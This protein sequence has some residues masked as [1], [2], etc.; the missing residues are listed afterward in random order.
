MTRVYVDPSQVDQV[1]VNLAVNARD[2][3]PQGSTLTI[4]T[5]NVVLDDD[6]ASHHVDAQPGE[7]VLLVMTDTGVGI[8]EVIVPH[9]FEPFFTTKEKG[10][11]TGLGLSTV[12]GIVK[13]S[14]RH[15]QV[16]SE[17]GRGSAFQIYLPRAEGT[18]GV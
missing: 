13:K 8:D 6:Y 10:K 4:E 16:E 9:I 15:I 14:G 5:K 11:G 12:Y 17:L 1:V 2:A 3:M 7:H 18:Q